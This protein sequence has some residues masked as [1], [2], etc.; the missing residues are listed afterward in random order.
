MTFLTPPGPPPPLGPD[1]A[2]Q[3]ALLGA[4]LLLSLVLN[5]TIPPAAPIHPNTHGITELRTILDPGLEILP[6]EFYGTSY[7]AFMRAVCTLTTWSE[8]T[9]YAT[10]AVLGAGAVGLLFLLAT[11]LGFSFAGGLLAAALLAL[12]PAQVW[13]SGAEGPMPL[14]LVLLL[15][16]LLGVI[17]GLSRCSIG[18]FWMGALAL[19]L[20]SRLHVLTLAAGPLGVLF[21]LWARATSGPLQS[22]RLRAHVLLGTLTSAV[23]WA[24]HLWSLRWVPEAF[25]GKI[26]PESSWYQFTTGNI[27]FDPTLT[28]SAVLVLLVWGC[29]AL[30]DRRK[31]LGLLLGAAFAL[32]GPAGLLV[33]SLRT[34]A[35]RYQTPTHWV[36]FLI[37]G[38]TLSWSPAIRRRQPLAIA[39]CGL[40]L[41][42]TLANAIWGWSVVHHGTIDSRA[43]L[44]TRS[45][46][47]QLPGAERI[48]L[49]HLEDDYRRL[50][51]D[52]PIYDE[53]HQVLRNQA[54]V[55]GELVYLG[56]DCYRDPELFA[57]R[58]TPEGM[59][60]ECQ[61]ACGNLAAI[62][63]ARTVLTRDTLQVGHHHLFH[64][65]T[66]PVVTIGLYRCQ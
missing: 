57:S 28:A 47:S 44:F 41:L 9:V 27:L 7:I 58:F 49:P 53:P 34:D 31:D 39:L 43:Y 61:R 17:Q 30:L 29:L 16:G 10:N 4:L 64:A 40:L 55:A 13:L 12:H 20:A 52:I 62:P 2:W 24:T 37:A 26:R 51:V 56:L 32:V 3:W 66:A 65:L 6:G 46:L 35:V 33:N 38:A 25:A 5:L 19:G 54:P 23:L 18:W 11:S 60:L 42:G 1:R 59:R 63:V 14:Y 21:A 22:R 36:L 45:A 50:L 15:L 48:H 8:A